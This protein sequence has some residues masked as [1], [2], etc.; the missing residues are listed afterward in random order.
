MARGHCHRCYLAT[1]CFFVFFFNTL[2]VMSHHEIVQH[3]KTC[4][5]RIEEEK[6]TVAKKA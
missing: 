2:P 5:D 4:V 3:Q 1:L 6:N